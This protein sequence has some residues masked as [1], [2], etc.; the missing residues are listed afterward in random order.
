ML[1]SINQRNNVW[2]QPSLQK[3]QE[4]NHP[5]YIQNQNRVKLESQGVL[6]KDEPVSKKMRRAGSVEPMEKPE[7]P[8]PELPGNLQQKQVPFFFFLT[9]LYMHNV[10]GY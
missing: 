5:S 3:Y 7:S 9:I 1:Q 6:R 2:F 4:R 8:L 10:Y